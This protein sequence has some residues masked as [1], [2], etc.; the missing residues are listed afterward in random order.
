M[1]TTFKINIT[2]INTS[3]STG[4][5]V[6]EIPFI[7]SFISRSITPS[8]DISLFGIILS[9]IV[10]ASGFLLS[11]ATPT[12]C[13]ESPQNTKKVS[14]YALA[15]AYLASCLLILV[16]LLPAQNILSYYHLAFISLAIL[17]DL[18]IVGIRRV[19]QGA[20]IHIE[21]SWVIL[22]SSM[23]RVAFTILICIGLRSPFSYFWSALI[24]LIVAAFID[25]FFNV[26]IYWLYTRK[27]NIAYNRTAYTSIRNYL[28]LSVPS[29]VYTTQNYLIIVIV[30]VVHDTLL[31]SNWIILYSFIS[32]FLGIYV[33]IEN[34]TTKF[35]LGFKEIYQI[36]TLP[37]L[38][39][40]AIF[41][42]FMVFKPG[43]DLYFIDFQG[44]SSMES[45][46]AIQGIQWVVASLAIIFLL[47]QFFKGIL[48]SR[49]ESLALSI[50]GY[51]NILGLSAA[52]V[53]LYFFHPPYLMHT[54]SYVL[55]AGIVFEFFFILLSYLKTL[56][57][58]PSY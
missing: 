39:G 16:F 13:G 50:S 51:L 58:M 17:I 15:M 43:R 36:L 23:A 21:K 3:L 31:I 8:Q 7:I 25:T 11:L 33:D 57:P 24:I 56:R 10:A 44:I 14:S 40:I 49:G 34:I 32:I 26:F 52:G 20:L 12:S 28:L 38:L 6:I 42:L 22:F 53:G 2:W 1:N 27:S 5:R 4:L 54:A 29:L 55:L 45:I 30:S 46:D 18:L 19:Y 41:G 48:I 37:L 9:I 47:K 35:K